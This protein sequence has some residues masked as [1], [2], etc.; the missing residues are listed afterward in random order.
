MVKDLMV[1]DNRDCVSL[2]SRDN[3]ICLEIY[4]ESNNFSV[5]LE[6]SN[7]D[8]LKLADNINYILKNRG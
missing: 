4:R 8:A 7:T 1:N 2:Q 6:M 5:W 3:K